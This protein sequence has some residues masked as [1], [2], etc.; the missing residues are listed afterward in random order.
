MAVPTTSALKYF[1]A[2]DEFLEFWVVP[3]PG[4]TQAQ[5]MDE[6]TV[7]MRVMRWLKPNQDNNFALIRQEAF[8]DLLGKITGTISW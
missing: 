8:V 2:D 6:V 3:A 4:Y 5:A 7:S 1:H